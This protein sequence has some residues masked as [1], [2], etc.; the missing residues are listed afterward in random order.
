MKIKINEKIAVTV[1]V[2]QTNVCPAGSAY[3]TIDYLLDGMCIHSAT[4]GA[5][6]GTP[7]PITMLDRNFTWSET[8][9]QDIDNPD[10]RPEDVQGRIIKFGSSGGRPAW[11]E[12]KSK[13]HRQ[14]IIDAVNQLKQDFLRGG[15][16][17]NKKNL[18]AIMERI[19]QIKKI[20]SKGLDVNRIKSNI[21]N[22]KRRSQDHENY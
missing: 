4:T 7:N 3:Y 20:E 19:G 16:T 14:A 11:W 5:I 22:I 21:N 13:T 12:E 15:P 18:K 10:S 1:K 2:T 9:Y 6:Y 8:H 17:M